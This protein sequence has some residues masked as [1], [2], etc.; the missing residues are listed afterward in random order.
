LG[1]ALKLPI[2][3]Q[4]IYKYEAGTN[5][6]S[7]AVALQI[8]HVLQLDLGELLGSDNLGIAGGH[9]DEAVH[10]AAELSRLEPRVRI[11][12]LKFVRTITHQ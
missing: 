12:L 9:V 5:R 4:Q 3:F 7:S 6:V 10:L 2:S 11:A 1:A 8:S